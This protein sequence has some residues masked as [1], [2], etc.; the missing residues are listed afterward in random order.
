MVVHGWPRGASR[1][2]ERPD[3][4]AAAAVLLHADDSDG[5]LLEPV[6][7]V[8]DERK[9][10]SGAALSGLPIRPVLVTAAEHFGRFCQTSRELIFGVFGD[11]PWDPAATDPGYLTR[12]SGPRP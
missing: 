11:G 3:W 10:S 1:R 8:L 2:N 9:P 6:D 7:V 12:S 4:I 5:A